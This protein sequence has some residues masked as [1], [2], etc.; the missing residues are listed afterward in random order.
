MGEK[1]RQVRCMKSGSGM[2]EAAFLGSVALA[3]WIASDFVV[4]L[5]TAEVRQLASPE[6]IQ[7]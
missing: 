1:V 7:A 2:P 4:I 3:L 6:R 5:R